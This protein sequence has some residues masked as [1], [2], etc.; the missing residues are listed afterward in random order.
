M[1]KSD[2]VTR[3]G[4][5]DR[6]THQVLLKLQNKEIIGEV[7]APVKT[8]KEAVVFMAE[9]PRA[10]IQHEEEEKDE[11]EK[12]EDEQQ[13]QQEQEQQ[14][15]EQE[16]QV[17]PSKRRVSAPILAVKILKTTLE[18]FS[19]R[20]EYYNE[21][22][23][24]HRRQVGKGK[25]K[26]FRQWAE[27]EH[28]NLIRAHKAGVSVPIPITQQE[29]VLVMEFKASSLRNTVSSNSQTQSERFSAW[30]PAPQLSE[31]PVNSLSAKGW[32][33]LFNKVVEQVALLY[34]R[35]HL[36]HSDLSAYNILLDETSGEVTLIDFAQAVDTTHASATDY[37]QRDINNLIA[38]FSSRCG[39]YL[40]TKVSEEDEEDDKQEEQEEQEQQQEQQQNPYHTLRE[41]LLEHITGMAIDQLAAFLEEVRVQRQEEARER[42]HLQA[43]GQAFREEQAQE[44][45][46]EQ[47]QGQEQA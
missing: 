18:Q 1:E 8:G 32:F 10:F 9:N 35:A 4:V 5:I 2:F 39:K 16:Q 20:S 31:V 23:N 11:V 27:K 6:N 22:K 14:E 45:A 30:A 24:A 21:Q 37:L 19:N 26:R 41:E 33:G 40:T 15:Q 46:Q 42:K 44:Q 28:R 3:D 12:E 17:S 29:H 43:P 7:S 36:V 13:E 34:Q 47:E 25:R 38:F